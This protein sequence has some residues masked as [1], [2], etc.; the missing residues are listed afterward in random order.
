MKSTMSYTDDS[1][2]TTSLS[3]SADHDALKRLFGDRECESSVSDLAESFESC[4]KGIPKELLRVRR[5]LL[6]GLFSS[7]CE[8]LKKKAL[9][10]LQ[11]CQST[12]ES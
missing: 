4:L 6:R 7:S 2:I 9:E 1:G 11:Q 8:I 3:F 12:T 5:S 10:E